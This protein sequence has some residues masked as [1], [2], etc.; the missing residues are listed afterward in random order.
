MGAT[1]FSVLQTY[2]NAL[3][4]Q[5]GRLYLSGVDRALIDQFDEAGRID[6]TGP[7]R[8][9][10]A[11]PKLGESTHRAIAEA[12]SFLIGEAIPVDDDGGETDPMIT[13]LY[14]RVSRLW[15]R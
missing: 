8:I 5:G 10:E 7:I 1:A 9:V 6:S 12:E 2:A 4:D 15:S 11:T 14:R 3:S 13:R